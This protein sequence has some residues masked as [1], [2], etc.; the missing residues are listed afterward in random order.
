MGLN[1]KDHYFQGNYAA[2]AKL[3]SPL[4]ADAKGLIYKIAALVFIGEHTVA[5]NLYQTHLKKFKVDELVFVQFHIGISYVRTSEYQSAKKYFIEN[6]KIIRKHK[7]KNSTKFL[8]Y[9]GIGFYR[10]FFSDHTKSLYWAEKGYFYLTQ[11]PNAK[12][13]FLALSLDLI[14]HNLIQIGKIQRGL[15]Q[16]KEAYKICKTHKLNQLEN[17]IYTSILLYQS[18][19]ECDLS[20]S[21]TKLIQYLNKSKTISDYSKSGLVLQ[22]SKLIALMGNFTDANLF[23]T[24]HFDVVYSSENKRRIATLNTFMADLLYKKG[25]FLEAFSL[26]KIARRNLDEK[27]DIGLL[28]PIL[29]LEI[30]ILERLNQPNKELGIYT[31]KLVEQSDRLLLAREFNRNFNHTLDYER[32]EDL[33]GDLLDEVKNKTEKAYLDLI[34]KRILGLVPKYFSLDPGQKYL[35][36]IEDQKDLM[37]VDEHKIEYHGTLTKNEMNILKLI[38]HHGVSK[39]KL[40]HYIW[41]YN[42]EPYRHDTMIYSALGRIK[43]KLGS[44]KSWIFGDDNYYFCQENIQIV[45]KSVRQHF[46]NEIISGRPQLENSYKNFKTDLKN[47]KPQKIPKKILPTNPLDY[48]LNYR[49]IQTLKMN[50]A[51]LS[52]SEYAKI[53]NVTRMTA[54]RDLK[55]LC[56]KQYASKS[57]AGKATRYFIKKI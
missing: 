1:V 3:T 15:K 2:A 25:Q 28:L 30:K 37:S 26:T 56:E 19:Y 18:D 36:L 38:S 16:L 6:L 10:F 53:W 21:I 20:F 14:G 34:E 55:E 48:R 8:S 49:Q 7:V 43:K 27:I 11:E 39:E 41:G 29:F 32:G 57:G 5:R 22:I 17:D 44:K 40:V 31:Q 33:L 12:I 52:V 35:V 4:D 42:Y 24:K 45:S 9:Q 54:L 23:L 46:D 51:P 13:L 47:V 50:S